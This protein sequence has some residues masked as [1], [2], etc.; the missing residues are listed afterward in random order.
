MHNWKQ[1]RIKAA[2]TNQN[3]M[4]MVNMR[5]GFAV[6]GDTQFLPG[7]CVLLPAEKWPS[8]E[9]MPLALRSDYLLDMSLIGDAILEV[10]QPLR[11]N[12]SIYGNT[13]TYLHAH[14]FPRYDWE[15]AER[16]PHPVWQYP[17]EKWTDEQEQ[18]QEAT[19]GTL[20]DKLTKKLEEKM[21]A[22]YI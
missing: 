2:Q 13:D 9:K 6:I 4:V 17:Q 19:H 3:P 20:R 16:I 14:L 15:P 18:F 10:C 8:L 21:K 1:D 12:Y 7:Y 11:V 22:A 5:S